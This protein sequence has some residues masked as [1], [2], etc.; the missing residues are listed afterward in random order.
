MKLQ[1]FA[2]LLLFFVFLALAGC[3]PAVPTLPPPT[4][5]PTRSTEAVIEA[6]ATAVETEAVASPTQEPTPI[7]AASPVAASSDT[8][9]ACHTDKQMLID[10][11]KPQEVKE[12]ENEGAG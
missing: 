9:L 12:S 7:V 3:G 6:P 4:L 5:E 10:T 11:A 1:T 8:C 2:I